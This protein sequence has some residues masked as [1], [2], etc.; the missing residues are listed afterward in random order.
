MPSTSACAFT[1]S[2]VTGMI[3]TA[4]STTLEMLIVIVHDKTAVA[5][6]VLMALILRCKRITI[7]TIMKLERLALHLQLCS[8][9]ANPEL[10]P[11]PH[12]H[13]VDPPPSHGDYKGLW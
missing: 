11:N 12:M 6:V 13:Q 9:G 7:A 8:P 2:T 3:F 5:I 10:E 4:N 1:R